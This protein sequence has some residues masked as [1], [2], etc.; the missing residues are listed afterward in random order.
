[1][2]LNQLFNCNKLI[3]KAIVLMLI[4][5][6][7]IT[8]L[9]QAKIIKINSYIKQEEKKENGVITEDDVRLFTVK[10]DKV[11]DDIDILGQI[12]F[13]EKVNIASKVDGRIS[14][15][16]I[17]EGKKV[18]KGQLIA[19]MERLS[20]NITL[21]QQLSELDISKKSFE[22]AKAKYEN[23]L[24]S[25]EIKLKTIVKAGEELNDKQVSHDNMERIYK[26]K[27]ELYK[28]GAV[29]ETEFKTIK[30]QHT[31]SYTKLQLAKSDYEI[32]MIGYRDE[33][34]TSEG[35]KI[36]KTEKERIVVLKK[37]NTKIERAEMETAKSR[38][39]QAENNVKSTRLLL[40]ETYIKSPING[41]VATKIMEAGEMVKTDSILAVIMNISKV[42]FAFNIN[43]TD[44]KK[45]KLGQDVTFTVDAYGNKVFKG[46]ITR[47]TPVFDVKTR[48]AEIKA[49]VDNWDEKLKPGMFAR[50]TV[51]TGTAD[52]KLL[53]PESSVTERNGS[54]G[55]VF[56]IK[57]NLVFKQKVE[58]GDT[59]KSFVEIKTG[60][61]EGDTIISEGLNMVY[62][63]M[64]IKTGKVRKQN[65]N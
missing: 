64:E 6:V 3:T 34:I 42:Y 36:P 43:E 57:K 17:L 38:I 26:N 15:I 1:M 30:T 8:I 28:I 59:Y 65:V 48:T 21:A 45:L 35:F 51:K 27:E 47:M 23:A 58:I 62:S 12:A 14:G 20:L 61:A 4:V 33:D 11:S 13:F 63:G 46:R 16:Y 18:Y 25:V 22:L 40:N 37:I 29:S 53:I 44:L 19:E 41:I 9:V 31:S 10:L 2:K 5:A 49:E 7:S 54:S 55:E 32:Q 50:A 60:L 39:S 56:F 52:K 24:K